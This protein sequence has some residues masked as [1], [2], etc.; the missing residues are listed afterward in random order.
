MTD[1]AMGYGKQGQ[2]HPVQS[3]Y[4]SIK[5]RQSEIM[6]KNAIELGFS[7]TSRARVKLDGGKKTNRFLQHAERAAGRRGRTTR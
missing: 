3:P 5:N 4:E 7:P 6:T 2:G 1:S